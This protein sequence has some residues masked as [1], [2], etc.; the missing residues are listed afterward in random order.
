M[1]PRQ[2]RCAECV[3][4]FSTLGQLDKHYEK[5]CAFRGT[6]RSGDRKS[7]YHNRP[8]QN[9]Q[10]RVKYAVDGTA[11]PAGTPTRGNHADQHWAMS[12]VSPTRAAAAAADSAPTD[13]SFLGI[14]DAS[15][16]LGLMLPT[17]LI[18]DSG[19]RRR[20]QP[21]PN[22]HPHPNGH[23]HPHSQHGPSGCGRS[24]R[25]DR[26]A[27]GVRPRSRKGRGKL[28][29]AASAR[30]L[31]DQHR[32]KMDELARATK[33]K[34][35]QRLQQA[36]G[37]SEFYGRGGGSGSGGGGQYGES[38]VQSEAMRRLLRER[39]VLEAQLNE[40]RDHASSGSDDQG[41]GDDDG[42]GVDNGLGRE[43]RA[44]LANIQQMRQDYLGRGGGNMTTLR[45]FDELESAVDADHRR[46]A[47]HGRGKRKKSQTFHVNTEH[48]ATPSSVTSSPSSVTSSARRSPRRSQSYHEKRSAR[49]E[50]H[51]DQHGHHRGTQWVH[52]KSLMPPSHHRH[53]H[54]TSRK[55][56]RFRAV[57][58]QLIATDGGGV[59][60]GVKV[61]HHGRTAAEVFDPDVGF[62]LRWDACSGV[63]R[64]G[65]SLLL[66]AGIY[67]N[68]RLVAGPEQYQ[69]WQRVTAGMHGSIAIAAARDVGAVVLNEFNPH[70]VRDCPHWSSVYVMIEL[71]CS[72]HGAA[73]SATDHPDNPDA[74]RSVG[75]TSF[76]PLDPQKALRLGGWRLTLNSDDVRP[77]DPIGKELEIR[78]IDPRDSASN[79]PPTEFT[80]GYRPDPYAVYAVQRRAPPVG[81]RRRSPRDHPRA[82]H[83]AAG[84]SGLSWSQRSAGN[85]ADDGDG[86]YSP[87]GIFDPNDDVTEQR[88]PRTA[89]T[90]RHDTSDPGAELGPTNEPGPTKE[91][92]FLMN[93]VSL[94][95]EMGPE[96]V[97][98]RVE[99]PGT[100]EMEALTW[101]THGSE[102]H[103]DDTAEYLINDCG[104]LSGFVLTPDTKVTVCCDRVLRRV[105]SDGVL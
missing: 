45:R 39:E 23:P 33:F 69:A 88:A 17:I 12:V 25:A 11:G 83:R 85:D 92:G 50:H 46:R 52:P 65:D 63:F 35:A 101:T 38:E 81:R 29:A 102:P 6:P 30:E 48:R 28:V 96:K 97:V 53:S 55:T 77:G 105:C 74:W 15:L 32:A 2:Y 84:L 62:V 103:P 27:G 40:I 21:H 16:R 59:G 80:D 13:A 34:T 51:H 14:D 36:R 1:P 75:W 3:V 9:R 94:F 93:I 24:S 41:D 47:R 66:T 56:G 8:I 20:A 76:H 19:N 89:R 22:S 5:F 43:A 58:D 98:T 73:P 90:A 60:V 82:A 79:V 67:E 10:N 70:K 104:L 61:G 64:N 31:E 100:A 91:G 7:S 87:L 72:E 18:N 49:S 42:V 4:T 44:E 95:M 99:L 37:E 57:V 86:Y 26:G 54:G 71:F 78:V 68:G